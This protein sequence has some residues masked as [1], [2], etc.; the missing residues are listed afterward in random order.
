MFN[1]DHTLLTLLIDTITKIE[2]YTSN[3][4]NADEF[5]N[6]S[7]SFDATLMNFISLGENISKLSDN[8][9]EKHNNIEWS[10]IYAFR[11]VIAH[12]YFGVDAQEVW[13]IIKQHL[14]LFKK[15]LEIIIK[16]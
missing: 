6:D 12:D 14:P 7:L 3:F 11:N 4:S 2:K 9:K 8:F 16:Q 13:Q 10:K 15:E 5:W 1:K